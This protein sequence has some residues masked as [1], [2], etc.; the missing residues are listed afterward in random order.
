MENAEATVTPSAKSSRK[1]K[2]A[3]MVAAIVGVVA[4]AAG[5]VFRFTAYPNMK[6]QN[7]LTAANSL[8]DNDFKYSFTHVTGESSS[9]WSVEGTALES[10]KQAQ[11]DAA[12]TS[13]GEETEKVSITLDGADLYINTKDLF[14]MVGPYLVGDSND[15]AYCEEVY[16]EVFSSDTTMVNL[17]SYA[18]SI[19]DLDIQWM[20]NLKLNV[21]TLVME[22]QNAFCDKLHYSANRN[23]YTAEMTSDDTVAALT[24]FR[25]YV[26]DNEAYIG[27]DIIRM[28][29]NY[30]IEMSQLSGVYGDA[31]IEWTN[32][33]A[34]EM[35]E[36]QTPV[37]DLIAKMDEVI[38]LCEERDGYFT[39]TIQ[40][41]NQTVIET[42]ALTMGKE[43]YV[44]Q[45]E[46]CPSIYTGIED[47]PENY[48]TFGTQIAL[49]ESIK[50]EI[51]QVESEQP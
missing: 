13:D 8:E 14:R 41:N 11:L 35:E 39:H 34:N 32:A 36:S 49:L 10:V 48:E 3:I 45:R 30:S 28:L 37:A 31:L 17:D 46:I 18:C 20:H 5:L 4:V 9:G 1:K 22:A 38:A 44:F 19:W 12:K 25:N 16:D 24:Q 42:C 29:R 27:E 7:L 51:N 40:E 33:R 50:E 23:T 47:I 2:T 6:A 26:A 15:A 21:Q 43:A